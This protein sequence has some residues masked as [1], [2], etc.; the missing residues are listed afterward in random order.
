MIEDLMG[1]NEKRQHRRYKEVQKQQ[2]YLRKLQ[3]I[4]LFY[5]IFKQSYT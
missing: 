2:S 3:G 5:F 1:R 4:I